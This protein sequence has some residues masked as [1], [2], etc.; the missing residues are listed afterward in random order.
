MQD[1]SDRITDATMQL[2]H[3]PVA[4]VMRDVTSSGRKRPSLLILGGLDVG[5]VHMLE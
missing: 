4:E 3:S 5:N 1:P 2:D